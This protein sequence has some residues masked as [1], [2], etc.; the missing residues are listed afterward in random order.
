MTER[1]ALDKKLDAKTFR[2]FYYLKE[3]LAD[4]CKA[5]GIPSTGGKTELT[6]RIAHYLNTGEILSPV[7][8]HKK[9]ASGSIITEEAV[10]ESDFVCS[11]NRRAFFRDKIGKSFSFNVAFQKWLKSNAGN[12]YGQAIEA[13]GKII[14]EKKRKTTVIDKQF[15]YNIYIRAFFSG[16]PEKSLDQGIICWKYKKSLPGHNRYEKSD[17]D[18]LDSR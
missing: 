15:E 17:L 3:E 13:Y 1:P 11:E 2:N 5:N 7:P 16:N 12:T 14:A 4:F 6:E 8:M 18:A 9:K 10:I